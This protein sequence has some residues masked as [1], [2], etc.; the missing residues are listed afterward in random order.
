MHPLDNVIWS[1]LTTRQAHLAEASDLA[2]RFASDVTLLGAVREPTAE[3]YESLDTLLS[4][5]SAEFGAPPSRT[6]LA[7]VCLF[8][9]KT[10]RLPEGWIIQNSAPMLQMV[11]EDQVQ[12][13]LQSTNSSAQIT[14][15][16]AAD[17]SEMVD[18]AHLTRPGPFGPRTYQ[19]GDYLGIRNG[20]GAQPGKMVAM[21]GER[22]RVPGFTEISA[23]CTR[24]GYT[25][26]GY[27]ALLLSELIRR[28]NARGEQ[29][30]LH[31]R[32]DNTRAIELYRRF[33]FQERA[34]WHYAV[35]RR[36]D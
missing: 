3:A 26:R 32:S 34:L 31:V 36:A 27:A 22:L 5:T 24:P 7:L 4:G 11:R 15:L 8:F 9:D 1:A 23:V 12:V 10:P 25:G 6:K 21:A 18:L 30:F 20:D 33:G 16:G 17:S 14:A 13:P 19:L 28:I 29:P 35:V 2:R